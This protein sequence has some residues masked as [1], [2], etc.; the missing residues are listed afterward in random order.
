M[1][2][3]YAGVEKQATDEGK[4]GVSDMTIFPRHRAGFDSTEESV[5]HDQICSGSQSFDEAW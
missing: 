2:I 5:A 4:Y 3:T 1:E